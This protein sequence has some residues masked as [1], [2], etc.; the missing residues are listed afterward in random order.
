MHPNQQTTSLANSNPPRLAI[1]QRGE[2]NCSEKRSNENHSLRLLTRNGWRI[3]R[4]GSDFTVVSLIDPAGDTV[5]IGLG[6]SDE[7]AFANLRA[8]T[9]NFSNLRAP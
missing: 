9:R 6:Q 5:V 4:Q 2:E 1:V 3:E 7:E 8:R